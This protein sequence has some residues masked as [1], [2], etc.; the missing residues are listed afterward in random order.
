MLRLVELFQHAS[1]ICDIAMINQKF[2]LTNVGKN[3]NKFWQVVQ[4]S[5][6]SYQTIW[7]RVGEKGTTTNFSCRNAV[8]QIGTKIEQKKRKGY[9]PVETLEANL[10]SANL[11]TIAKQQIKTNS[12]ICQSLIEELAAANIHSIVTNTDIQFDKA[13]GHFSTPLGII[14]KQ[15]IDSARQKLDKIGAAILKRQADGQGLPLNEYTRLVEDYLMLIPTN[16]GRR[17]LNLKTIFPNME[18]VDGQN[19]LLDGLE[20]SL[21]NPPKLYTKISQVFDCELSLVDEQDVVY[22]TIDKFY[23][24]TI[25]NRHVSRNLRISRIFSVNIKSQEEAFNH[26]DKKYGNVHRLWHGTR[27]GNLLSILKQGLVI[28]PATASHCTARMFGSGVYFATQ[29]TKSLNYSYGYWSNNKYPKCYMFLAD[30]AVGKSFTPDGVIKHPPTGYDS[31]WA[32]ANVSKVLNDEIIVFDTKQVKLVYL[33][34]P[35]E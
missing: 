3:N 25:N 1:L 10:P 13:T 14:T 5:D 11:A 17:K 21:I 7:G 12:T 18:A 9:R 29:S 15:T 4:L 30:V 2:I 24:S 31:I 22:H 23:L 20:A 19:S 27:I 26:A 16:L 8:S 32:K 34:E 6:T 28:P 35:Q 33:I